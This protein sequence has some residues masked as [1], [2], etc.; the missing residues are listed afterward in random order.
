VQGPG[1]NNLIFLE[2]KKGEAQ[3][4]D[5]IPF[6]SVGKAALVFA[7]FVTSWSLAFGLDNQF[8]G[9]DDPSE[10]IKFKN[11][12]HLIKYSLGSNETWVWVKKL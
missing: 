9:Q 6:G 7:E 2:L 12:N 1:K 3:K 11:L 8:S 4:H 5:L 10:K